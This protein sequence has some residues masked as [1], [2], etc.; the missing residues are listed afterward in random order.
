M[1]RTDES[2]LEYLLLPQPTGEEFLEYVLGLSDA[3]PRSS[4]L[5]VDPDRAAIFLARVLERHN[6]SI[7]KGQ[8][9]SDEQQAVEP[10]KTR[11]EFNAD[12]KRYTEKFGHQNGSE[13]LAEGVDWETALERQCDELASQVSTLT[14]K[15]NELESAVAAVELG[16]SDT[17]PG[18]EFGP[19]GD[20]NGKPAG[21]AGKIRLASRNI[22]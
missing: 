19:E 17:G 7:Q 20:I 16:E 12:L 10:A 11:D 2:I 9:V 21:F 3:K 13:W 6:L 8:T 15:V 4:A 18:Q 1:Q 14:E 5:S 22:N